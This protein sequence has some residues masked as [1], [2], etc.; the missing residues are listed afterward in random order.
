[1]GIPGWLS[2]VT[3]ELDG[4]SFGWKQDAVV[5]GACFSNAWSDENIK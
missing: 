3:L 4:T 1:M 2:S 5:E